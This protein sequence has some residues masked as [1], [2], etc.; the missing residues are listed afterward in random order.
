MRRISVLAIVWLFACTAPGKVE[1]VSPEPT[2]SPRLRI[3]GI[4]Q[5]GGL[6]HA[7]CTCERCDAA[8][9]DPARAS[10]VASVAV[11]TSGRVWI[12]DATPDLPR[13]L[14]LLAD[15]RTPDVG[16]VDRSR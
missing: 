4:A 8:R 3:L 11:I 5:D 16:R 14:D 9:R 1:S 6:P 13:Q 12:V 2:T 15:V 10:A 7:A